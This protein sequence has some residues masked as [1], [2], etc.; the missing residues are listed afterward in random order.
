MSDARKPKKKEEHALREW[1]S[2][3]LR[4][5]LLIAGI[6]VAVLAVFLAVR[7]FTGHS[8]ENAGETKQTKQA[9]TVKEP[10]QTPEPTQTSAPTQTPKPTQTSEP[11][12][13]PEPTVSV[14]PE[15]AAQTEEETASQETDASEEVPA[16]EQLAVS[17]ITARYF[18]ALSNGDISL[19]ETVV[20]TLDEED[21]AAIAGHQFAENYSNFRF[22]TY[23]GDTAGS[24]VVFA[25]YEYQYP[26]FST[27]L[28]A[29]TELYVYTLP[30]GRMCIASEATENEKAAVLQQ[31]LEKEEVQA[32]LAETRQKYDAA[33]LSDPALAGYIQAQFEG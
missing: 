31:A 33:L 15:P 3:N 1:V 20:E 5:I 29:L 13:T 28:P 4:Y 23:P 30:D 19:A 12:Q 6:A 16:A 24:Y 21:R 25:A 9:E 8:A 27:M 32:L 7:A 18:E 10:T 22:L 14:Q 11:T 26:G 17:D 2:D